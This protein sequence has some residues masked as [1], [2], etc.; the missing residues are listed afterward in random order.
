MKQSLSPRTV[1]VVLGIVAAVLLA[2]GAV[3]FLAPVQSTAARAVPANANANHDIAVAKVVADQKAKL[4]AL[5]K[6]RQAEK[7]DKKGAPTGSLS[8]GDA[9]PAAD[10]SGQGSAGH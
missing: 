7:N 1:A 2:V 4:K 5:E 10:T 9:K 8:A 6:S 3:Y